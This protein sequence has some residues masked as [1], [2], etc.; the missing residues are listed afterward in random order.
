MESV[1]AACASILDS[2]RREVV[3]DRETV[4]ETRNGISLLALKNDALLSYIA[5]LLLLAAAQL[6][7]NTEVFEAARART[8]EQRV[9]LEKG[10]KGLEAKISYQID[11]A[12]RAFRRSQEQQQ[13]TENDA[14]S[15]SDAD[16]TSYRPNVANLR[17][18]A[19]ADSE[20]ELDDNDKRRYVVPKIS[21]TAPS[22]E[23]SR[24]QPRRRDFAMEDYL[25]ETGDAPIAEASIGSQILD[26]GKGG[27][28]TERQRRKDR[29]VQDYEEAN[30]TRISSTSSKRARKEAAQ[31]QQKATTSQFFGEDWG[32]LD[33][34]RRRK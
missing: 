13:Q 14:E 26:G 8:I 21:S 11:K 28:R 17:K 1:E 33:N 9:T 30:F 12:L 25:R 32:F 23:K 16:A 10:V 4:A 6:E 3:L 20:E 5:N 22:F 19:K 29:E 24:G 31:R 2:I 34:K 27:E 15:D 7:Q 18:A